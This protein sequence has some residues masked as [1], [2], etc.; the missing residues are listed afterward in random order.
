GREVALKLLAP[1]RHGASADG[2]PL[3]TTAA[4]RFLRE[5]RVTAQLEHPGIVPVHEL[6]R[7]ADG[8]YY[9]TQKVVRG[10]TLRAALEACR[11]LR[12]LLQPLSHFADVCPAVPF[13]YALGA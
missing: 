11:S 8:S 1:Q 2:K 9:Y 6:G 3:V 12:E 5:A 4:L 13:A 7:R 10:R